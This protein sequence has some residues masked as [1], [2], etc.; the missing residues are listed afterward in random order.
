MLGVGMLDLKET[1]LMPT[2]VFRVLV[3]EVVEPISQLQ[4]EMVEMV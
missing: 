1:F 2:Q 3:E 4:V